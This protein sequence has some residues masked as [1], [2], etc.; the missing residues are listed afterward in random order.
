MLLSH[1][2]IHADESVDL[3]LDPARLPAEFSVHVGNG[4]RVHHPDSLETCL[5]SLT[6]KTVS[7]DAATS[8]AWFT[9]TLQN[10]GAIVY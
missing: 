4:V 1:A 3:F 6:G 9:L 5:S 7:V 2:I 10:A 8:N